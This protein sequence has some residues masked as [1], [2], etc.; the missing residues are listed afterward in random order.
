[1]ADNGR[2]GRECLVVRNNNENLDVGI[3]FI[4]FIINVNYVCLY[5]GLFAI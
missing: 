5:V 2:M 1:M 3:M 4:N